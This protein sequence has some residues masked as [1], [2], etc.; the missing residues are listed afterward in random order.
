MCVNNF[1]AVYGMDIYIVYSSEI[2]G[3][4]GSSVFFKFWKTS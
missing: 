4:Y 1:M 3:W 2:S